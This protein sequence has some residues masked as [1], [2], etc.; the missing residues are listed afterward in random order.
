MAGY[1]M[2]A[3]ADEYLPLVR[4]GVR[5]HCNYN[6]S[7]EDGYSYE[8]HFYYEFKGD[9]IINGNV[10]KK[11]YRSY[12][13]G[14]DLPPF[15]LQ[16]G[17]KETTLECSM[18][19]KDKVVY[20]IYENPHVYYHN[21][22]RF[23]FDHDEEYLEEIQ[24]E[25]GLMLYDFNQPS[26]LITGHCTIQGV[27]CNQYATKYKLWLDEY[28]NLDLIEGFGYKKGVI[29]N[30]MCTLPYP[31]QPQAFDNDGYWYCTKLTDTNNNVLFQPYKD[32]IGIN[33]V[34]VD[35]A[36]RDLNYYNLQGQ[37]V[38]IK[39]APAGIYI[40]GGKKVVVK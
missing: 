36:K 25:Y 10:Y 29:Y 7:D 30:V 13:G 20:V 22:G 23:F 5:W 40:H 38:D 32:F 37:A 6:E 15:G 9:T 4:E 12:T 16:N 35:A 19:E 28:I 11:L 2:Q 17:Y 3:M 21:D 1:G 14:S 18:M 8:W 31:Y 26:E 33:D 27:K 39:S 34:K 24:T